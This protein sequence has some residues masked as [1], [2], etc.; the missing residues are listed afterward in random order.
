MDKLT[1]T[2]KY[3]T[4]P[5]YKDSGVEWLGK[6]PQAW[7]AQKII[8]I[9]D[10][11]N[12][13]VTEDT[14]QPLSVTYGGVKRQI[15]TAAKVADGSTRKLVR[16]GDI[17]INARSDR[18]GAVGMSEFEGGV[19][20]VYNILRK[21]TDQVDS[22]YYHHLF[23]SSIF[24]EE[25]YRWG[26]GIVD[27]LWTT[28]S[29]EMKRIVVSVPPVEDQHRISA[30]LEKKTEIID[31]VIAKKQRQIEL[32]RERRTAFV[33]YVLACAKGEQGKL[34]NYATVN[35][36]KGSIIADPDNLVSFVP[37]EALSET[38]VLTP[39]EKKFSE[40]KNGFTPFRENDV[41]IAK[42]T[43]CFENGKAG[44]MRG[45]LNGFGF[46]TTE[47]IV[48]RPSEKILSDYLYYIVFSDKFRKLGEVGMKGSAG[49]KR[50]T[51]SFVANYEIKVPSLEEQKR[52]ISEIE[53]KVKIIDSAISKV[54]QTI[55]LL[56]E[57]KSSLIS[58]AVTG[59]I[60]I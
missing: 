32:M 15:E 16:V 2:K 14:H 50:V 36:S 43:P 29:N 33:D 25:F 40:V 9:F 37:M 22:K 56:S 35:P 10:F 57:F 55:E 52:L 4:Y 8:S 27:D 47:F 17:A 28:R 54:E 18:K 48:L 44:V 23:R 51:N 31:S 3:D 60:R 41:V 1:L 26:R 5:R 19:S 58:H 6:I 24:S 7:E 13:K 12:E 21:R 59:K 38:G 34:K 49:Q 30:Y 20:L 39:R 53:T 46:G 45:L 42:I 11:P